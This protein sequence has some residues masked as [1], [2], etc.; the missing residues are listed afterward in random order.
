MATSIDSASSIL[1]ETFLWLGNSSWTSV[2]LICFAGAI[3]GLYVY[4]RI[5]T[6]KLP[7]L[8]SPPESWLFGH[9]PLFAKE[10][11]DVFIDLARKYGPIYRFNFG[12]QPLVIVA[13]ADL[14]REVGVK[15]FKSFPNRSIPMSMSASPL[16]VKGLF[17]TKSPRWSSMRGAIQALYQPSHIAS[18]VPLMERTI[19]I[20]KDYLSTKDEKE[21]INFTDLLGKVSSDIIGE[22]AFGERF[23]LT[24]SKTPHLVEFQVTEFVK[25]LVFSI[26]LRLD[27]GGTFS[28]IVCFLFPILQKPVREILARIPGTREWKDEQVNSK[29]IQRL[30][31]FV[32]KRSMDLELKSRKDFLSSVL[33]ARESSKDTRD[34]FT[35][36]YINALAYEHVLVGS[37]TIALTLSMVLYLISAH[38]HVE[39]KLLEEIDAFGPPGRNPTAED[40]D[41]FPYL[42]Q[43][44]K[45][46][47]RY[48]M[49]SPL[50]AR[51]AIE[52]VEIGGYLFPKGTWVWLALNVPANDSLHFPEPRKFKPER[53]DP[54]CEEEKKRHPYAILPFGI[55]PRACFG[56]R[57]SFQEIKLAMIHLYQ[58]FTFEHSPLMEN[59]LEFQ[60]GIVISTKHGVKL[61]VHQRRSH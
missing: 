10:G 24:P 31:G 52:D 27:L 5:P 58:M 42:T 2:L 54:E 40:L 12:R 1:T 8:P 50:V 15:K 23:N 49:V 4:S 39:K 61:R 47:M 16:H 26:S 3:T 34:L 60:Y 9:L 37:T 48:Y 59:P 30:N 19:C 46:A 38:P 41:K 36:D 14:C 7:N 33:T 51:E 11:T 56:M 25:E 55:G 44:I 6:W 21:D 43:V 57:F 18:Q 45:E 13:D 35:P 53:F 20:L 22:A 28:T 29:L 32:A 17:M